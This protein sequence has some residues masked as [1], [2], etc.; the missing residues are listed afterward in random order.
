[1]TAALGFV[2]PGVEAQQPPAGIP[3]AEAGPQLQPLPKPRPKPKGRTTKRVR[4]GLGIGGAPV[5]DIRRQVDN[6]NAKQRPNLER[7]RDTQYYKVAIARADGTFMALNYY[8]ALPGENPSVALLVHEKDRT[9]RDFADKIEDSKDGNGLAAALQADG[10]AVIS[11]DVAGLTDPRRRDAAKNDNAKAKPAA[12]NDAR[13]LEQSVND[14]RLTY[15]FLVDRHN[16]LEFNMSK[17]AIITLGEGAGA[18][19]EWLREATEPP[20]VALGRAAA[21]NDPRRKNAGARIA[22][23]GFDSATDRPSDVAALIMISPVETWQNVKTVD[24]MKV[25]LEGSPLNVMAIGGKN[26]KESADVIKRLK[27]IVERGSSRLSKTETIDTGLH[28]ARLL[29]FEPGFLERLTRFLE[30]TVEFQ[31]NDWEPRYNLTP[32]AYRIMDAVSKTT[33]QAEARKAEPAPKTKSTEIEKP[34]AEPPK[35][36]PE[37]PKPVPEKTAEPK[38]EAPKAEPQPTAPEKAAEP[39]P[40]APSAEP[41]KSD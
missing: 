33:A 40:A 28:G 36:A 18:V 7:K 25:L 16:R 23:G 24:R 39:K 30:Q 32:V 17:M 11:I 15:Q 21:P 10:F 6:Q 22:G 12:A 20:P 8:P 3:K 27:P 26:D 38:P 9:S 34:K 31:K 37:P 41:P 1:M 5:A 4:G 13:T 2:M 29:R 35:N 19:I 14:L